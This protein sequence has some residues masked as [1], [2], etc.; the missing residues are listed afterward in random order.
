MKLFHAA[1]LNAS[2]CHENHA[3]SHPAINFLLHATSCIKLGLFELSCTLFTQLLH[4][5]RVCIFH[6]N[7]IMCTL[8]AVCK[9]LYGDHYRDSVKLILT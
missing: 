4:E 1:W 2:E 3:V 5:E 7:V 8:C 6:K 9:W